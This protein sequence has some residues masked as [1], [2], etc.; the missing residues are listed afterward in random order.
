MN[1]DIKTEESE[2]KKSSKSQK[3]ISEEKKKL[4]HAEKINHIRKVNHI[5]VHGTH[6]EDPI[7]TFGEMVN[8]CAVPQI[9][10][11]NLIA[12]GYDK[13]T[14]IQMQAIPI[15]AAVSYQVLSL[16]L[17][18]NVNNMIINRVNQLWHVPQL[19]VVKRLH[20]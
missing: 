14:A 8:Q 16:L 17:S 18:I 19:E 10:S 1:A 20:F 3:P 6:P 9:I 5:I 4:L 11:N 12:S 13:L 15:M 2:E 7:E